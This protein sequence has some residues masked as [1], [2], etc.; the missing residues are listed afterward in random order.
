MS[1]VL[2]SA[3]ADLI[4]R[5]AGGRL[6]VAGLPE[7]EAVA[8][9]GTVAGA[10]QAIL[11][12]TDPM[13]ARAT[14]ESPSVAARIIEA[15]RSTVL[16]QEAPDG[17]NARQVLDVMRALEALRLSILGNDPESLLVQ[18]SQPDALELLVEVAHDLRS[19]LTSILFLS[20]TL[21][22]GHSGEVNGQQRSQLGLIYGAALGLASMASDVVDLAREGR[23]LLDHVPEPYALTEVVDGVEELVRPMAEEKGIELRSVIPEYDRAS[24]HPMALRR[25]LLNL[26]SNALKF[27]DKGS[28]EFGARRLSSMRIEF[29]VRDTGRGISEERQREIFLPF[30]KREHS[31]GHFFSGS[32]VGLSMARRLVHLMGSELELETSPDQGTRFWFVLDVTAPR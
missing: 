16:D 15:L 27:T 18:L 7:E 10:V 14:L 6:R 23:G 26:V 13:A 9:L 12:G 5:S 17:S 19:P 3:A 8:S 11:D 22:T 28:V 1:G 21:R 24:G 30:K 4:A 25:V 31:T 29:Y 32:G 20:E 2:D